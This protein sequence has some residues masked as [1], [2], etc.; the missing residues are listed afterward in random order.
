[1]TADEETNLPGN[2]NSSREKKPVY[3]ENYTQPERN[4]KVQIV[5]GHKARQHQ[6][7]FGENFERIGRYIIED[8]LLPA[9]KGALSDMV[10]NG[11]EM[12]LYGESDRGGRRG[13]S[14]KPTYTSYSSISDD[15]GRGSSRDAR[16]STG[17]STDDIIFETRNEAETL[18]DAMLEVLGNYDVVTVSDFYEFAGL[19]PSYVDNRFGWESLSSARVRQVRGGYVLELPRPRP[20][21]D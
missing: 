16:R 8:I 15:R 13:R 4:K 11:I 18:L 19:T 21:A 2:S 14:G 6:S 12:L 9:A 7:I 17:R 10:S 1:M 20:I 3:L 5:A